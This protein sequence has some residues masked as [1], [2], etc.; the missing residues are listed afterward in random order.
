MSKVNKHVADP[1]Q[2]HMTVDKSV[3]KGKTGMVHAVMVKWRCSVCGGFESAT[4]KYSYGDE[5]PKP[6]EESLLQALDMIGDGEPI[7]LCPRCIYKA[8]G[9]IRDMLMIGERGHEI[10]WMVKAP[11]KKRRHPWQKKK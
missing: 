10:A 8:I 1:L 6:V 11:K 9:L 7:H 4:G 5:P 2:T 3:G